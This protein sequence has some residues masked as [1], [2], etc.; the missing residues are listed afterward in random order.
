MTNIADLRTRYA[1]A[2]ING[3]LH[4]ETLAAAH[5]AITVAE[6]AGEFVTDDTRLPAFGM[7]VREVD[8]ILR[9]NSSQLALDAKAALD[10]MRSTL[11]VA[12]VV[13]AAD[14]FGFDLTVEVDGE[15]VVLDGPAPVR[16]SSCP[17][18]YRVIAASGQ[19]HWFSTLDFAVT[20]ALAMVKG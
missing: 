12:D 3:E 17:S 6:V 10:S 9:L 14:R 1:H 5:A 18:G 20:T 15:T 16:L 2:A 7:T 8:D 19:V 4:P 11:S 13:Q